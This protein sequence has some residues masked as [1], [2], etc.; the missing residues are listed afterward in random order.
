[1]SVDCLIDTGA[2][3]TI[4]SEKLWSV[5]DQ[6]CPVQPF[7]SRIVSA[8]GNYLNIKGKTEIS[9]LFGDKYCKVDVIIAEIDID[10][11][12]GLDFM[13]NHDVSIDVVSNTM[14]LHDQTFN[15]FCSGK[16][17]CFRIVL[18]EQV[19]IPAETE[20][21][22]KG[23]VTES[24]IKRIGWGL[25]E[26]S[27]TFRELGQGMVARTLVRADKMVPVRIAN[28]SKQPQTF[29]PGTNVAT[30]CKIDR[31]EGEG[32][33]NNKNNILPEHLQNLYERSTSGMATEN[34]QKVKELLTRYS[35]IFSKSDSDLGRTGIIKHHIP[36]ANAQ[37]IKQPIRRIPVHLQ[38][39]VEK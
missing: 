14:K 7:D 35:H 28:F 6:Q 10:V 25:I 17:G 9:I 39:E 19:V 12:L 37:P 3:L 13:Q 31:V 30:I 27:D 15:I 4:I 5:I 2:T 32:T 21:I 34:K 29:Y 36:T 26:A 20:M 16:I 38:D 33:H 23:M 1:M 18:S 22:T 24:G 11:V 8:S